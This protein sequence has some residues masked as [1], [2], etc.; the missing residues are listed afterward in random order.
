MRGTRSLSWRTNA[1]LAIAG[2]S[3][4]SCLSCCVPSMALMLSLV[5]ARC[6]FQNN[7][8]LPL[9]S[10]QQ[11]WATNS[12]ELTLQVRKDIE[13]QRERSKQGGGAKR[14]ASQHKKVTYHPLFS[15]HMPLTWWIF[16]RESWLLERGLISCVMR[17][18]LSSMM[19]LLSTLAPILEWKKRRYLKTL[20]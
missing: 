1:S 14:I 19:H 4:I 13:A 18:L 6:V 15:H 20:S 17:T 8:I 16:Y 10:A 9:L 2:Q 5:R 7:A 11:R 3:G 12:A